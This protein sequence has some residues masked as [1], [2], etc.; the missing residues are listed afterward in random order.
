MWTIW[1]TCRSYDG[2]LQDELGCKK[3]NLGIRYDVEEED[4][5]KEVSLS[6]W[7]AWFRLLFRVLVW[8]L[9]L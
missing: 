8:M 3:C 9:I 2:A 1:P 6:V 5:G 4:D 7:K